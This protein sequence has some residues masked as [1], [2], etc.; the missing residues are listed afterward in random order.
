M[1]PRTKNQREV[2]KLV[3]LIGLPSQNQTKWVNKAV[4]EKKAYSTTKRRWCSEC[5]QFHLVADVPEKKGYVTCPNCGAKLKVIMSKA[6][7][8]TDCEYY[9]ALTTTH[10]WTIYR[11]FLGLKQMVKN[12]PATYD[13]FEVQDRWLKPGCTQVIYERRLAGLGC[14]YRVHPYDLGSGLI[15]KEESRVSIGIL[16]IYPLSRIDASYAK[17]GISMDF[18]DE[19]PIDVLTEVTNNSQAETLWKAGMYNVFHKF[20]CTGSYGHKVDA[21]WDS[22]KICFRNQYKIADVDSWIDYI[23]ALKA[24]GLDTR[25]S[26][27]VCPKDFAQAHERI[28]DRKARKEMRM[29]MSALSDKNIKY[30]ER[31]SRFKNMRITDGTIALIVLP[32]IKEFKKEGD[33]LHHCVYKMKYYDKKSSL[34]MSARIDGQR[35]EIIEVSLKD[36]CVLQCHGNHN[37]PSEYHD[38]IM[39]LV[40]GNMQVIKKFNNGKVSSRA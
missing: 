8:H 6:W 11:L 10:G 17:Y 16:P 14:H 3:H 9:G 7:R 19:V 39:S 21:Y 25:N 28:I 22:L 1:K 27:Y 40:K 24:I 30:K 38:E 12:K 37:Q 35:I 32:D 29:E 4:F 13:Y 2:D 31:I 15:L 5:G 36:Y 18:H 26:F 23:D 34:I 33:Y 20:F